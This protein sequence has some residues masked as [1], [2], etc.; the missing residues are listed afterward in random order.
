MIRWFRGV[1]VVEAVSYLVL[2]AASIAK[3]MFGNAHY[4]DVLG[5]V[6]GTIFL[7]YLGMA[8]LI[9]EQVRW[10]WITF[11]TVAIAAAIPFGAIAVERRLLP[12]DDVPAPAADRA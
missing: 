4:V 7:V 8:L 5:P 6:H 9:R 3:H 2:L 10:S 1:A 12:H 11:G